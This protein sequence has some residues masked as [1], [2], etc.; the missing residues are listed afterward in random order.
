MDSQPWDQ[1]PGNCVGMKWISLIMVVLFACADVVAQ[2]K[3]P[4]LNIARKPVQFE[5]PGEQVRAIIEPGSVMLDF[6]E[7]SALAAVRKGGRIRLPSLDNFTGNQDDPLEFERVNLFAPGARIRVISELGAVQLEPP[8]LHYFL[9][10]NSTT[11]IGL[12]VDP[13]TGVT[14]GYAIKGGAELEVSGELSGTLEFT[15]LETTDAGSKEC[16]TVMDD[17]PLENIAFLDDGLAPSLSAAPAGSSLDFEAVIAIDTDTEW[18]AGF[19]NDAA[20]ASNWIVNLFLAMN[21]MFERD[22]ATRLL[23][24]DVILRTESDPYTVMAPNGNRLPQLD[25]FG[26]YWRVKKGSIDRDFAAMFSGRNIN[27]NSFSGIAWINQYCQNGRITSIGTVGSYS[28]NAIGSNWSEN[29]AAKFVGHELGHNMGSPHT[30]CYPSPIDQC[31]GGESGCYSGPALC[32]VSG[33][34]TTMSYC[35]LNSGCG[36]TVDFHPTVQ[37]LFGDRLAANSP[38]CIA[39]YSDPE[40]EPEAPLFISGFE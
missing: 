30:H 34:G 20:A 29:S 28:Y 7:M 10:T 14:S 26:E 15:E 12:A 22:I 4:L 36:S 35:H 38:A 32:P 2:D 9:A 16:G 40:P 13:V 3:S 11:G 8:L 6:S 23:L 39:P 24:G 25:E 21:V 27:A 17:Q 1:I 33:A 19:N 31:Y 37:A 18:L 5:N